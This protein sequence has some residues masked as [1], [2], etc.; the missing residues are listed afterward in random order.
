MPLTMY[1]YCEPHKTI[2]KMIDFGEKY[3]IYDNQGGLG[4]NILRIYN[5]WIFRTDVPAV[6]G[7][8]HGHNT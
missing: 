4:A 1:P 8:R 2:S 7:N 6:A 5:D 3:I